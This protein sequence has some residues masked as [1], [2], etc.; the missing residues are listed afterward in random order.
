MS[1]SPNLIGRMFG[2]RLDDGDKSGPLLVLAEVLRTPRDLRLEEGL[3]WCKCYSYQALRGEEGPVPID[4][5]KVE[6]AP[7]LIPAFRHLF[8]DRKDPGKLSSLAAR[9][10]CIRMDVWMGPVERGA[11]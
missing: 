10:P 3:V 8:E 5:L 4:W 7:M 1:K 9:F 11:A 2:Y 6:V